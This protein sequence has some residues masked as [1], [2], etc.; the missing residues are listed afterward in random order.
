MDLVVD[1]RLEPADGIALK[2]FILSLYEDVRL[3]GRAKV[4]NRLFKARCRTLAESCVLI[5]SADSKLSRA[6]FI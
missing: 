5:R 1:D 4:G 2:Y 3:A 6:S